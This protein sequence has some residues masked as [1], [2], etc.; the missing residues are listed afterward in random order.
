M[1]KE[2]AKEKRKKL[3][4]DGWHTKRGGKTGTGVL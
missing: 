2:G 4:W 3:S 1:V